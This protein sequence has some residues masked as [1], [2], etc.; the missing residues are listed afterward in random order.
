MNTAEV[1]AHARQI[2][3]KV[4][5]S[6]VVTPSAD[7]APNARVVRPGPLR[8]DWSIGFMTERTCRKAIEIAAAGRFSMVFQCDADQAYVTLQGRPQFIDDVRVKTA[9]WSAE[10]G[11]F[12]PNGPADPNVVI[13][14]LLVDSIEIYSAAHEI[15]PAPLGLCSLKLSRRGSEWVQELTSPR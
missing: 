7:G 13:I 1:L 10:S 3:A 12:H 11:R 15:Q 6:L 4:P 14:K 9:V 5:L 2:V 8:E